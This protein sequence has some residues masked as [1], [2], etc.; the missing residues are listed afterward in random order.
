MEYFHESIGW[1]ILGLI[2]GLL[3]LTY[4]MFAGLDISMQA[5]PSI[6]LYIK[7]FCTLVLG[8]FLLSYSVLTLGIIIIGF[9]FEQHVQHG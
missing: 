8:A 7:A 1:P 4:A 9:I 6:V 2:A 5:S 3:I